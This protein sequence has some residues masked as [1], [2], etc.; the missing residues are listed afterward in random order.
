MEL[1]LNDEKTKQL[2]KE[3]L[4]EMIQQRRDLFYEIVLEAIEEVGLSRAIE[5]GRKNDFVSEEKIMDILEGQ[6]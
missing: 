5:E 4:V 3:V 1:I 2:L 6:A